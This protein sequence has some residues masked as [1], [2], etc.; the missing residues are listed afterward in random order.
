MDYFIGDPGD[1]DHRRLRRGLQG[2]GRL[3]GLG[4]KALAAGK[5]MLLWKSATR[6]RVRR[7]PRRTA[8]LGG[9]P[10]LYRAAF[11]QAGAI[12]VSDVTDLADC[13]HALLAKRLPRGNR[14]AIVTISGGAGILMADRCADAGLELPALAPPPWRS[15]ARSCRPSRR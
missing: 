14:V 5:P 12:E 6:R 11:R 10:A 9:A 4:R 2:C 15:C 7:P 13:A 1:R 8:N 3:V